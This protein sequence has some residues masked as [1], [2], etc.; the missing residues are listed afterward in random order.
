M[1]RPLLTKAGQLGPGCPTHQTPHHGLKP[2]VNGGRIFFFLKED[3]NQEKH[4][5]PEKGSMLTEGH[6]LSQIPPSKFFLVP[7]IRNQL[8]WIFPDSDRIQAEF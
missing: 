4:Y 3:E 7:G 8:I 2:G 5:L 1:E 6:T